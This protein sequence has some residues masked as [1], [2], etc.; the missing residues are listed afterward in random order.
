MLVPW[1]LI[2]H[3]TLLILNRRLLLHVFSSFVSVLPSVDQIGEC[4]FARL[5]GETKELCFP[6]GSQPLTFAFLGSWSYVVLGCGIGF[7]KN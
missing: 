6:K 3:R 1:F 5:G 7:P 2:F 4:M